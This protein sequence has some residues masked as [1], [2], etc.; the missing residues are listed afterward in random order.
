MSMTSILVDQDLC[1]RC[2]ICAA[3]C[4]MRLLERADKKDLPKLSVEKA[5]SCNRC[6][7]CEAYCPSLALRLNDGPGERTE[8]P[9]EAGPIAPGTLGAYLRKRRSVRRFKKTPV[10]RETILELLDVARYAASGGN[11][12]PV[13]WLVIHDS[14]EVSRIAGL[15][16]EWMKTLINDSRHPLSPYVPSLI[17]AWDEGRD[18]ICRGAPHLLFAN[19]PGGALTAF[20]DGIIALTHFDVT[21]PA[22]GIGT[23]WAGSVAM[24]VSSY[25]PLRRELAIPAGW[26]NAYAMMF[27]FPK[28]DIHAVPPRRA[29]RVTWRSFSRGDGATPP[30]CEGEGAPD[31]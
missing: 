23:C 8:L 14:R 11:S 28:Y 4:S 24:A 20:V 29:L 19:V 25:E 17:A 31:R 26:R 22:H 13:E 12:Q 10:P 15:T 3:V 2:G 30:R 6:G 18:V 5:D 1:S 9:N 21:A 7:H 27:G 16:I